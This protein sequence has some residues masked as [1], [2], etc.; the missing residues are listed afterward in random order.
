[1]KRIVR[2]FLPLLAFAFWS[3]CSEEK[4]VT[5]APAATAAVIQA[6]SKDQNSDGK[7]SVSDGTVPDEY[8]VA[9]IT[10]GNPG[11]NYAVEM[12]GREGGTVR[13]GDFEIDVPRGAVDHPTPFSIKLTQS[14]N[15]KNAPAAAEFG[16]H[17]Q[18]FNVPVTIL[19]PWSNTDAAGVRVHVL[20]WDRQSWVPMPSLF[21][22]DGRVGTRTIH[23]SMYATCGL[24][25]AGG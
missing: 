3:A 12:I 9:H 25:V 4:A 18:L 23:F 7:G 5:T 19:L 17:N 11:E 16:P 20:W 2:S 10:R 22:N 15:N 6:D 8:Q 13:L 1:M 21:T 14:G 24:T